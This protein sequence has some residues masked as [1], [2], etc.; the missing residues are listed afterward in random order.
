MAFLS[1]Y[2]ETKTQLNSKAGRSKPEQNFSSVCLVKW[3]K[4]WGALSV[5]TLFSFLSE[6][7]ERA[8]YM[9]YM[10]PVF[11]VITVNHLGFNGTAHLALLR[12][13]YRCPP[14]PSLKVC[15]WI[16]RGRQTIWGKVNVNKTTSTSGP[17]NELKS[18]CET[19]SETERLRRQLNIDWINGANW[20]LT[21]LT[22]PPW[23]R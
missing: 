14:S 4:V 13:L 6:Y 22:G 19:D 21:P 18:R 17:S 8:V 1:D 9:I 12:C 3:R 10:V 2:H 16:V 5:F 23:E 20:S 7:I 15:W 11:T